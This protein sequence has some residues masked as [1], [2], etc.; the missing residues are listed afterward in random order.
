[1]TQNLKAIYCYVFGANCLNAKMYVTGGIC[2][3][4]A[5]ITHNHPTLI[6]LFAGICKHLLNQTCQISMLVNVCVVTQHVPLVEQK[7]LTLPEHLSLPLVFSAVRVIR[8]LILYVC[9]VHMLFF[10]IRSLITPLVSSRSSRNSLC[11]NN[12]IDTVF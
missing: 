3:K 1:L 8:S 7:L 11:L 10:D 9:F 4:V 6:L 2:L 12:L 5:L